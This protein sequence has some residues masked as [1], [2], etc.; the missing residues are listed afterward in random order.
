[1]DKNIQ[2]RLEQ[3]EYA[4]LAA[5]KAVSQRSPQSLALL[6]EALAHTYEC[7]RLAAVEGDENMVSN[8]IPNVAE[9]ARL[10]ALVS[11]GLFS[12]A[13]GEV[14]EKKKA[15]EEVKPDFYL[16]KDVPMAVVEQHMWC[17]A[18]AFAFTGRDETGAF[19]AN[20]ADLTVDALRAELKARGI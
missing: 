2:E 5:E 6:Q 19:A 17:S 1:M 14:P 12:E 15:A 7:V 13:M 9:Y 4:A 8:I 18:F 11:K 3:A 16:K 20:I 10:I